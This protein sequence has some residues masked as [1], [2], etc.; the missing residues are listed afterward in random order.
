MFDWFCQRAIKLPTDAYCG[1]TSLT[2]LKFYH[3]HCQVLREAV[4]GSVGYNTWTKKSTEGIV[5]NA[6][7]VSSAYNQKTRRQIWAEGKCRTNAGSLLGQRRRRWTSSE[8]ASGQYWVRVLCLLGMQCFFHRRLE[9]TIARY[10]RQ[11]TMVECCLATKPNSLR[12]GPIVTSVSLRG[13]LVK[14]IHL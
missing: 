13:I 11:W 2:L 8:P 14:N 10:A 12:N 5:Q 7:H 6:T 9:M 4:S 1:H 3:I